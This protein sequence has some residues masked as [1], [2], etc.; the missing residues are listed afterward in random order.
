MLITHDITAALAT[1]DRIAVFYAGI[2]VESAPATDFCGEGERL[3]HPYS[4][5]LW[6]ALPQNGFRP[7]PGC[8]PSI[9]ELPCGCLFAP[10]CTQASP[11]CL[12]D[13]PEQRSLR[14][15]EVRCHHAA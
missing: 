13:A 11:H 7:V 12:T 4:K 8:Q 3:R 5:A 9:D 1:A 15:G 10:R 14:D 2:T 6:Q